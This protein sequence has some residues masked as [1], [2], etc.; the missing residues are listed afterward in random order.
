[1]SAVVSTPRLRSHALAVALV[2]SAAGLLQGCGSMGET[3]VHGIVVTESTLSAIKPGTPQSQ[4]I[5]ELGTPST[6]SAIGGEA[7]YYVSQTTSRPVA[8]MSP[9]IV[10]RNVLA[11]YF[12]KGKVIRVANYSLQDGKVF[13]SITR[14]TPTAGGDLSFIT[15]L[16]RGMTAG[17][18]GFSH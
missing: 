5:A 11:V 15:Q 7:Y 17:V 10:D 1:M 2:I 4:V 12:D 16:A 18:P 6:E 9:H 13:D 8:F 14:T 3:N